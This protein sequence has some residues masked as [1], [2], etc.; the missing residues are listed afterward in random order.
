VP[1]LRVGDTSADHPV[2]LAPL[3]DVDADDRIVNE[4]FGFVARCAVRSA[5]HETDYVVHIGTARSVAMGRYDVLV[6]AAVRAGYFSWVELEGD[7]GTTKP[8]L[9]LLEDAGL[10]HMILKD[11]R[12]WTNA[13]KRDTSNPTLTAP[14]RERDGDGC[15]WCGQIVVWSDRKGGRGGTY[16][17]LTPQKPAET[18]DDLV[19]SCKTCNSKRGDESNT[20]TTPLLPPPAEPYY[21]A[22][23]VTFLAKHGRSVRQSERRRHKPA[24]PVAPTQVAPAAVASDVAPT[25]VAPSGVAPGEVASDVAPEVAPSQVAPVVAPREVAP[26][27]MD[28]WAYLADLADI[29]GTESG[30]VG[31]GRDGPGS[32]GQGRAV[33]GRAGPSLAGPGRVGQGR[34][35]GCAGTHPQS[36]PPSRRKTKRGTKGKGRGRRG[37]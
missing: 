29:R 36:D 37:K 15:R 26:E 35:G 7:D 25:Q 12:E 11:E 4:L 10:F 19:V 28:P 2:A 9:K 6:P 8:A 14:V 18:P 16:D 33:P 20:W 32:A 31:T 1:W 17:H 23:T 5:A 21:S 30:F 22:A 24:S 34:D 13:R 27:D 3:E